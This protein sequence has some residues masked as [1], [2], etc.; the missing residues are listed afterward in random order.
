MK[1]TIKYL[2]FLAICLIPLSVNAASS[3]LSITCPKTTTA[4]ST[5][6]CT[7]KITTT[8]KIA[9]GIKANYDFGSSVSYKSL[10]LST[11]KLSVFT[12]NSSGFVLNGTGGIPATTTVGKLNVKISSSAT[13]GSTHKIGL[14]GIQVSTTEYEDLT[15]ENVSTTVRIKS[16]NNYLSSL[17]TSS[18]TFNFQKN[19]SNY[20]ITINQSKTTITATPEDSKATVTG[21]GTKTLK[22]G[23]NKFKIVVTSEAKTTRTYTLNITRKDTR[24]TE[25]RLLS[26]NIDAEN[27]NLKFSPDTKTYNI[28]VPHN[29]TRTKI[30]A[31]P[32]NI[33]ATFAKGYGPRTVKL[34]YGLNVVKVT[35]KSEKGTTNTYTL[36]ITRKD[37]RS[38]NN[39][40]SSLK[41]SNGKIKFNKDTTTYNIKVTKDTTT[42]DITASL[43]DTKA[44]FV[45]GYGPRTVNLNPGFNTFQIRV[46][47]E[48][49]K[50]RTY[51]INITREDGKS[52][53]NNLKEIKLSEGTITFDKNNLNY[54][55]TV[56]NKTDKINITAT[57]EDSKAKVTYQKENTLKVGEN[58]IVI[59]VEAENKSTKNYTI[60]VIRK[61]EGQALSNNSKLTT[62][63][64]NGEEIKLDENNLTYTYKTK[65]KNIDVKATP[66]DSKANVTI[67]GNNNI[68]ENSTIQIIVTAEDQSTT[69]YKI[70]VE[71][72]KTKSNLSLIIILALVVILIAVIVYILITKMK[73]NKNDIDASALN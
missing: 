2:I 56:E 43:Q 36:N 58:K 52:E 68:T 30:T 24:S 20:N 26:L 53:N 72:E 14:K 64:L 5:I 22:Y 38:N 34:K 48:K 16:S 23:L 70:N 8:G 69:T 21:T 62:L 67:T 61:E 35:V 12:S 6:T 54:N 1:K 29:V 11:D 40:L 71:L 9:N 59:K 44:S 51:T 15:A 66:V 17:K 10:V 46:K 18:G 45:K 55:V 65:E 33:K 32:Y 31:T 63:F 49:G 50:I 4:S 60:N 47:N 41:I 25:N 42:S 27:A 73:N 28:S 3:N 19:I 13:S 57:P 39:Y 7:I 37:N